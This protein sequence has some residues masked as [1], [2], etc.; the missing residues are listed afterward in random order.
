MISEKE[1]ENDGSLFF[2]IL[3]GLLKLKIINNNQMERVSLTAVS[4]FSK[5]WLLSITSQL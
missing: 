1:E 5:V 2:K 3:S 4:I